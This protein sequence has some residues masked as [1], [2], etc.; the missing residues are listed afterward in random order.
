MA[1]LRFITEP[2]TVNLDLRNS[3]GWYVGEGLDLGGI[4]KTRKYL[5]QE[6]VDGAELAK[7]WANVVQM[8][9]PLILTAQANSSAMLSL[10]DALNTELRKT[11]NVL[12]YLPHGLTGTTYLMDT[13]EA[14]EVSL[15]DGQ[16]VRT[17]WVTPGY[18]YLIVVRIDRQPNMRG[19]GIVV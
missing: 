14:D 11:T 12:E 2:S 4:E 5:R 13:F 3:S 6:G 8:T 16:R 18:G 15:A 17:P 7:S 1:I 10:L 9:I 19:R